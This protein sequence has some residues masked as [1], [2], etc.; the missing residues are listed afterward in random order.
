MEEEITDEIRDLLDGEVV[1]KGARNARDGCEAGMERGD[2]KAGW[3]R[4]SQ[5]RGPLGRGSR[6]EEA[7]ADERLVERLVEAAS[8]LRG[9]ARCRFAREAMIAMLALNEEA[10][11]L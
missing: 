6:R 2:R 3:R 5:G 1:T 9:C 7:V 10:V 8:G 4:R 11:G